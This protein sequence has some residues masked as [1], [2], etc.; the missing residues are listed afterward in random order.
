ML[1]NYIEIPNHRIYNLQR[2]NKQIIKV[3]TNANTGDVFSENLFAVKYRDLILSE[4]AMPKN[5]SL[6][7]PIKTIF[8]KVKG[9]KVLQDKM[10]NAFKVNNSIKSLCEKSG[11]HPIRY[12]A[13][14][15]DKI[16]NDLKSFYK[17]FYTII[18]SRPKFKEVFKT[19]LKDYYFDLK[20]EK[21]HKV[22][23]FCGLLPLKSKE[24]DKREAFDHYFAK[25]VYPFSSVNPNNLFPMCNTCNSTYK[26][27]KEVIYKS[28]KKGKKLKQTDAN[29]RKGIFPF[30]DDYEYSKL[31]IKM[32]LKK[33]VVNF[34]KISSDD[35]DLEISYAGKQEEIDGW[36]EVF[37][38]VK[39]FKGQI[40]DNFEDWYAIFIE[41]KTA[42]QYSA[43]IRKLKDHNPLSGMRFLQHTSL[44]C[45]HASGT[46][47]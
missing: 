10:K 19:D 43:E 8:D 5:D 44:E 3:W 32:V 6:Y 14:K 13:F 35:F 29:R 7:K 21:N 18:F 41:G 20:T 22:C 36:K 30:D 40:L 2:L 34:R 28:G 23:P 9:N 37:G 26:S 27:T 16:E 39:R 47:V 42:P 12:S 4:K 1:D 25:A 11:D 17:K 45:W 33:K 24:E 38:I 46:L 15:T 31:I